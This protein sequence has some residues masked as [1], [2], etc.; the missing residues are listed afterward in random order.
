MK[1]AAAVAALRAHKLPNF[2]HS[3]NRIINCASYNIVSVF[4]TSLI[5]DFKVITPS[6]STD[7]LTYLL[8]YLLTPCSRVP[9]EKPTGS[10]ASQEILRTFYGTR[11]FITVHTSAR[12]L[13]L[14][15]ANSIQFT[16][17][18]PLHECPSL[19]L[20]FH[21]RLGLPIGLFPSGFPHQN[22]VHTSPLPHTR[23]MPR[24]SHSS[25]FYHPHNIRQGVQITKLFIM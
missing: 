2:K 8:T 25:R 22:P 15:W 10:A 6:A 17:P 14:S 24:P 20:S 7:L 11:K 19:I 4:K 1:T 12:H 3:M 9:L 5:D 13:S 16:N 21:L 23:H 18:L